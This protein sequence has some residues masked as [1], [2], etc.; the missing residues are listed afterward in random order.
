MIIHPFCLQDIM[1]YILIGKLIKPFGLK[2]EVK[3]D[4]YTDFVKERFAPNSI[5]YLKVGETMEPMKVKQYRMH[6]G[7][8][9]LQFVDHEDINLI[10][11]YHLVEIY[12]HERDIKPLK[13]GE[14]FFRDL[15]GLEVVLKG[16]VVGKVK[17][18]EAGMRSNLLRIKKLDKKEALVA[19]LPVFIDHVD[20]EAGQII[21]KDVEGLL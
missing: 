10:E 18:V 13:E 5:V 2:G 17:D 4:I 6:K 8:L 12:K 3:V 15:V 11:K 7:Q 20:L 21:L 19:Y 16:E 9:L 14:Y 1:E